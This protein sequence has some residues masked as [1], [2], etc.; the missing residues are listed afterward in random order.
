MLYCEFITSFVEFY[1]LKTDPHQLANTYSELSP[2]TH[3]ALHH[4]LSLLR[5]CR[6]PSC[7]IKQKKPAASN[8]TPTPPPTTPAPDVPTTTTTPEP[9]ARGEV[10]VKKRKHQGGGKTYR[11]QQYPFVP[12]M[13]EQQRRPVRPVRR[14]GGNN[15]QKQRPYKKQPQ[16]N[17]LNSERELR[18]ELRK[19][20][21]YRCMNQ[22]EAGTRARKNCLKR[23]KMNP[24][25][26]VKTGNKRLMRHEYTRRQARRRKR[27]GKKL[28]SAVAAANNSSKQ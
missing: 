9:P 4:E 13:T 18:L 23:S 1:N 27:S 16:R 19:R 21:A 8:T 2:E 5:S 20:L 25:A 6:G 15:V 3:D 7:N 17:L 14:K 28:R 11:K 24:A 12:E 26:V 22:F 10:P